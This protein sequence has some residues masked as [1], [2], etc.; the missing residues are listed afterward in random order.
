M[1]R[2]AGSQLFF[3]LVAHNFYMS[4]DPVTIKYT[5]SDLTDAKE[6]VSLL[7]GLHYIIR[8][9][10]QFHVFSIDQLTLHPQNSA[11][12]GPIY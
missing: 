8:A 12:R 10:V 3:F 2:K 11:S 9:V 4:G 5:E 6:H 7:I 1:K